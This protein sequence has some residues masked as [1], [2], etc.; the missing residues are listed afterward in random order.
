MLFLKLL[1]YNSEFGILF[2]KK[3][4]LKSGEVIKVTV[5]QGLRFR[6]YYMTLP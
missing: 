5:W 4:K 2:R 1:Q 3:D 6:L